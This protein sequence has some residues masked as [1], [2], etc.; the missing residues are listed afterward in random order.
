[1]ASLWSWRIWINST[2]TKPQLN[3]TN[4]G[5]FMI[6]YIHC[7]MWEINTHVYPTETVGGWQQWQ[8]YLR[9][10]H[11]EMFSFPWWRHQMKTFSALL[12]LCAG[13]SPVPGNSPHNGQWRRALM[14]SLICV[15]TNGGV[16]NPDDGDLRRHRAHY[17]VI[18]MSVSQ[19]PRRYRLFRNCNQNRSI[20]MII[21]L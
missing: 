1:M 18:V 9:F 5:A 2:S 4:I 20:S 6:D 10:R 13:N 16:N 8:G 17:D 21:F 7:F 14:F 11:T 3:T 19:Y 15:W 12:A